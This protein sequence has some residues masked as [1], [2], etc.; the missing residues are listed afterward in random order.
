M[1]ET[2]GDAFAPELVDG[3]A[4]RSGLVSAMLVPCYGFDMR[5]GFGRS[6]ICLL[7]KASKQYW[8]ATGTLRDLGV[9]YYAVKRAGPKVE[10]GRA[11]LALAPRRDP[12]TT[13]S[14]IYI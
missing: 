2:D 10:S 3:R 14:C 6:I 7:T 9:V 11:K 8:R 5:C 12:W 4:G 13:C 1:A